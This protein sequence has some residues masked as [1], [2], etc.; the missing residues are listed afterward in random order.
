MLADRLDIVE[1]TSSP[2]AVAA[3]LPDLDRGPP[4]GARARADELIGNLSE[5]GQRRGL[6]RLVIV[7]LIEQLRI[8]VATPANQTYVTT[9]ERLR[10][11]RR[12]SEFVERY[13]LTAR[14]DLVVAMADARVAF[15]CA[16][17][18]RPQNRW[19]TCN[20]SWGPCGRH[21]TVWK[22][23]GDAG[24]IARRSLRRSARYAVQVL[25]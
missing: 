5:L 8:E 23:G 9:L 2:I 20:A 7:A 15:A 12:E 6:P 18:S 21:V 25:N 13:D 14:L 11:Y 22:C 24:G 3:S 1:R 19:P 17:T 10:R 4:A 16:T